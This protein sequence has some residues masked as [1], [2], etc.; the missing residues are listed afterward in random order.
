VAQYGEVSTTKGT[1]VPESARR[2]T[3]RSEAFVVLRGVVIQRFVDGQVKTDRLL[4]FIVAF[5][6]TRFQ[7]SGAAAKSA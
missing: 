7:F 5:T 2:K 4:P 1:K 6:P 3:V